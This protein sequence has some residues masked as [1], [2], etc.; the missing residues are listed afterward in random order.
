MAVTD[1]ATGPRPAG[2]EVVDEEV[3]VGLLRVRR[4]RPAGLVVAADPLE[5]QALAITGDKRT[6]RAVVGD[7]HTGE[8]GV[9]A[10]SYVRASATRISR[11]DS[12]KRSSVPRRRASWPMSSSSRIERS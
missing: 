6:L 10:Q 1:F 7:V 8:V 3:E 9:E 11:R 5:H 12:R 4:N 2:V